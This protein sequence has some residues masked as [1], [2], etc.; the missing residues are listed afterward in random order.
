MSVTNKRPAVGLKAIAAAC[1]VSINTVSRALR[2]CSDIS[3]ATKNRIRSKAIEMGYVPNRLAAALKSGNTRMVYLVFNNLKS[4]YFIIMANRIVFLLQQR[5]YNALIAPNFATAC[6]K[7][8]VQ[9][10][11]LARTDGILTFLE[12]TEEAVLIAKLNTI[13]LVLVGRRTEF[14]GIDQIYT[15]DVKGGGLA[16][17][18][19]I[20]RG[21]TKLLYVAANSIECSLRRYSGFKRVALSHPGISCNIVSESDLEMNFTNLMEEGYDGIFCFNEQIALIANDLLRRVGRE[22]QVPVVGYDGLVEQIARCPRIPCVSYDALAIADRAF[23]ALMRRIENYG[24]TPY[25]NSVFDVK[26]IN[27]DDGERPVLAPQS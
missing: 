2:D 4:P 10:A 5:G 21:A 8:N 9:E 26:L 22:E 11:L 19:L 1:N 25:E 15:D 12:P 16:A 27:S 18:H 7:E 23:E 13:P 20:G 17:E 14:D 3:K 6:T 24:A